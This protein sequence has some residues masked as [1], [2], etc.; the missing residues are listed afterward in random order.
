MEGKISSERG[1]TRRLYE[2]PTTAGHV[3]LQMSS[4]ALVTA[5]SMITLTFKEPEPQG[6]KVNGER[7]SESRRDSQPYRAHQIAERIALFSNV[8]NWIEGWQQ[9]AFNGG[10]D[11]ADKNQITSKIICFSKCSMWVLSLTY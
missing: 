10:Q 1:N 11:C 4:E 6:S 8:G 7:W 5:G 3:I 9:F 2:S